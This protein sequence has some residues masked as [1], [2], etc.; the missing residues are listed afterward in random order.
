MPLGELID[1]GPLPSLQLQSR[2]EHQPWEGT[3]RPHS[4]SGPFQPRGDGDM[5]SQNGLG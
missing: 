5:E 1:S 3:I 2:G 4:T